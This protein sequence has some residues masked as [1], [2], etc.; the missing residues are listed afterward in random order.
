MG[1]SMPM[2]MTCIISVFRLEWWI[3]VRMHDIEGAFFLIEHLSGRS[4]PWRYATNKQTF[5]RSDNHARQVISIELI[6]V[7]TYCG[8]SFVTVEQTPNLIFP[9]IA[10]T[11]IS[12]QFRARRYTSR[13]R[14]ENN[15]KKSVLIKDEAM[16]I[17]NLDRYKPTYRLECLPVFRISPLCPTLRYLLKWTLAIFKAISCKF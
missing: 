9:F 13:T 10:Y 17:R 1:F 15:S 4:I 8:V 7:D 11:Q 5:D 16:L 2:Q 14:R 12:S 3:D 6:S